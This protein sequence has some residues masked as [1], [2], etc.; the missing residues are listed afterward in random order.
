MQKFIILIILSLNLSYSS[1][2]SEEVLK[3]Q[4]S[5]E[6]EIKSQEK[7]DEDKY[8]IYALFARELLGLKEYSL[9]KE[10]YQKALSFGEKAELS[11]PEVHYNLLFIAY[12]SNASKSEL[13][14]LLSIVKS[15][16]PDQENK[17]VSLALSHWESIINDDESFNKDLKN[18]F[19]GFDYSQNKIKTYINEKKYKQALSLLPQDLK[20][21]NI[22]Y[23]I[24]YDI[25]SKLVFPEKKDFLCNKKLEKYPKS[26]TY[27]MQICRYL[28]NTK[29]VSLDNIEN[30][31][32]KES[33]SKT[34][35][36]SALKD[37]K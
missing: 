4:L 12:K 20:N 26:L 2:V 21:N 7:T 1:E 34:Y 29:S 11:M 28:N 23:Q 27:T 3:Y 10:Y 16:T 13:N 32:N 19:Y 33:S 14:R 9:A 31:I 17:Q 24:Q 36:L 5:V 22:I 8:Y 6:Q 30:Q 15:S 35:L 18:S 37:I 25:L